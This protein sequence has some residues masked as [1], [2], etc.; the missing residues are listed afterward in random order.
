MSAK[1]LLMKLGKFAGK[2]LIDTA[3]GP[4]APVVSGILGKPADEI[5]AEEAQQAYMDNPEIRVQMDEIAAKITIHEETQITERWRILNEADS[6]GNSTRPQVVMLYAWTSV[7]TVAA[8]IVFLFTS[9]AGVSDE[10]LPKVISSLRDVWPLVAAPLGILAVPIERYFGHRRKEKEAR[11]G[12]MT[13][14]QRVGIIGQIAS[15][16]MK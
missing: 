14:F 15:K 4:L 5:T 10:D 3:L 12:G 8:F 16:L 9:I 6:S 11:I 13:G 7:L 1:D 2:K